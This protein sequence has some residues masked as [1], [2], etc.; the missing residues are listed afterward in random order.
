MGQYNQIAYATIASGDTVSTTV[1]IANA[2][3]IGVIAPVVTSCQINI[4]GNFDTVSAG[5]MPLTNPAGSGALAWATGVGSN[6]INITDHALPFT[7]MRLESSV[8]QTDTRTFSIV[9]KL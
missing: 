9:T 5:F 6:A 4:R 8:A 2:R 7:Y 1:G 3:A